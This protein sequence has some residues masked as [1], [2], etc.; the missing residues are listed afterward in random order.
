MAYGAVGGALATTNQCATAGC[1]DLASTQGRSAVFQETHSDALLEP[2]SSGWRLVT[3]AVYTGTASRFTNRAGYAITKTFAAEYFEIITDLDPYRG[4]YDVYI[5][6][7]KANATPVDTYGPITKYQQV[8]WRSP[9]LSS[10]THTVKVVVLGT[11]N[12]AAGARAGWVMVDAFRAYTTL[13]PSI[14]PQCLS[15]HADKS[16]AH[17]TT[18]AHEASS[19][20]FTAGTYSG[21]SCDSCHQ[22]TMITEHRR[23]SSNSKP[24][25]CGNCHPTYAP[26][27]IDSFDYSCTSLIPSKPGCHQAANSQAPHNFNDG[28]H[29]TT[30]TAG[31]V[32]C[33]SCHGDQ[34]SV[35]HDDTNAARQQ[36]ASLSANAWTTN[37]LTCHGP[38]TFPATKDCADAGCHSGSGVHSMATHP[39]PDHNASGADTGVSTTGGFACSTCHFLSVSVTTSDTVIEHTKASSLTSVSGTIGCATCH[40]ASYF[41]TNWTTTPP[42]TN[43]CVACHATGKAPAP[44]G[45][46]VAKHN[47]SLAATNTAS[48]GGTYCHNGAVGN[49]SDVADLHSAAR[50]GAG[51]CTSC[52]TT[53]AAVPVAGSCFECHSSHGSTYGHVTLPASD[54]CLTCHTDKA[55]LGG[56][57]GCA[58]CHENPTLTA[59]GT[60]YIKGTF[61]PDC[62]S[63]HNATVLGTHAYTPADPNHYNETTHTAAPFTAAA[64][65]TGADGAVAAEG[66]EC[67]LCHT[68][69]LKVAHATT[70]IG[71]VNCLGCH[72]DTTLGSTTVIANNWTNDRCTDCHDTGAAT[73]HDTYGTD[74]VVGTAAGCAGSGTSCHNYT[75]L[76]KLHDKSQQGGAPKYSTCANTGCHTTKDARPTAFNAANSCGSTSTG[77]HLT[78]TT[79]NH[80]GSHTFNAAGSVYNNTTV[81]GCTDSSAGCHGAAPANYQAA[82]P[83]SGCITGPCHTAANHNDVAFNDPNTCQNC[84]GGGA[85]N[86]DNA[87]IISKLTTTTGANGGHYNET[88]HTAVAA[89]LTTSLTTGGSASA[90]CNQCHNPVSAT[91]VDGLY[92]QHQ[93]LPAPYNSTTC[94]DCHNYS[95]GVQAEIAAKWTNNTCEDCHNATD[96]P[97]KS[98]GHLSSVPATTATSTQGCASA[99]LNCHGTTPDVHALHKNAAGGCSLTGCHNYSAQGLKPTTVTCG[100]GGG[101]HTAYTSASHGTITGSESTHTAGVTQTGDTS[102]QS[103]ACSVCHSGQLTV[104]HTATT[105]VRT[106]NATNVCLNCHNNS[107]STTAITSTWA[108]NKNTTS[109]CAQ[110]HTGGLARHTD[111]SATAHTVTNA[112]C[113]N[114]GPGCHPTN[115][116]ASVGSVPTTSSVI[117]NN[118]ARCHSVTGAASWS[119]AL[120]GTGNNVRYNPAVKSCGQGTGCHLASSYSTST[121]NHRIGRGDQIT[122]DDTTH[123]ANATYMASTVTSGTA[124]NVCSDCH[125][126]TLRSEHATT[127][128]G[129]VGCTTGGSGGGGCHNTQTG[130]VAASSAAVVKSNWASGSDKCSDCHSAQHNAIGTVHNGSST[131]GCASGGAGCHV[132]ADLVTLHKNKVGGGGCKVSGCHDAANKSLRP[133]TKTCGSGGG[134][135]AT[136]TSTSHGSI[137]GDDTTHTALAST[138]TSDATL[139]SFTA[140]GNTCSACHSSTLKSAHTTLT[141]TLKSGNT[142]W[143]T[144]YCANCHNTTTPDNSVTVI[145]TTKWPTQ[146]CDE[147]HVT[148]GNGKHSG[149]TLANHTAT[150]G[151]AG[152]ADGCANTGCHSTGA[153][154]DVRAIHN[155]V[156]SG[157]TVKGT[158]S[159]GWSGGCHDLQKDMSGI[160]VACGSGSG[161]CHLNHTNNNHMPAHNVSDATSLGCTQCHEKADRSTPTTSVTDIHSV[162]N[163]GALVSGKTNDGC[164]ICHGGSGWTDV[165]ATAKANGTSFQCTGCHNG[166]V[167][168]AHSYTPYDPNHY[169]TSVH[170]ATSTVSVDTTSGTSTDFHGTSVNYSYVCITCHSNDLKTEHFQVSSFFSTVPGTYADKCVACHE[171]KVDGFAGAAWNKSCAGNSN[172]C[173]ATKHGSYTTKHDASA[174]TMTTPGSS[175]GY[176]TASNPTTVSVFNTTFESAGLEGWTAAGTNLFAIRNDG[177]AAHGGT[178]D[179]RSGT[180]VSQTGTLS[181]TIDVSTGYLATPLREISFWAKFAGTTT[182]NS[183]TFAYSTNGSTWTSK[184]AITA[185]TI[186]T[187]WTK[188]TY[189][190]LPVS[191]TL[192]L[193]FTY[194]SGAT[195]SRGYLDDIVLSANQNVTTNTWT[196]T[197]MPAGSSAASSC[198][199]SYPN[200]GTNC[201]DVT[202]MQNIHSRATTTVAS[203]TY[204]GCKVC[205]RNASTDLSGILASGGNGC[206]NAAF[207]CHVGKNADA[208]SSNNLHESQIASGG[209]GQTFAGTGFSGSWCTGCHD[210]SI[211]LEHAL[212]T[213]YNTNGCA[214]CH[215]K[216]TDSNA[217]AS[218]PCTVTAADTSAT[219]HGDAVAGNEL[220]TDCHKTVTAVSPHASNGSVP[221]DTGSTLATPGVQFPTTWSGHRVYDGMT[222]S[223]TSGFPGVAF[224]SALP[225][226]VADWISTASWSTTQTAS[227]TMY[228]RCSDCHGTMT[229]ATG[230]HGASMGVQIASGYTNTY[231]TEGFNATTGQING[232]SIC[233]KCHDTT[234]IDTVNNVHFEHFD[235]GYLC[236]DCHTRIPHAWK[237]PRLLGYTTDPA[238]YATRAGV[239]LTA[240]PNSN[241]PAP[242]AWLEGNCGAACD[243]GKHPLTTKWP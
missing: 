43:T 105:S 12:A 61:A 85:V 44:H 15:C 151:T 193:R 116:I 55:S 26:Y 216:T 192:Y 123:T 190:D 97:G 186:G 125:I 170:D 57:G 6:G 88:T 233:K 78:K 215:K 234:N 156:T 118:C 22:K 99:G 72:T 95:A 25:G 161:G 205:H 217:A 10:G 54:E 117:H 146:S 218:R 5:D 184:A 115:N 47:Y 180:T 45:S 210:D 8:T 165:H 89:S 144:P 35:I 237:R 13:P 38:N 106:L 204:T 114:S 232:T 206:Q 154:T 228:V 158:D 211:D 28:N 199:A 201:H 33:I 108:T 207:P 67:S 189:S 120:I 84:H 230:P 48:C 110:C 224:T 128:I 111:A 134:C 60:R 238:P 188:Y 221:S 242:T 150:L 41:P 145:K 46:T 124:T 231:A 40:N 79:T 135:H 163:L 3:G 65:G 149:Y 196:T 130:S 127:S 2:S 139:G 164:N 104:E 66:K 87:P 220:C 182:G 159:N 18:F 195:A 27:V 177:T 17:G 133:S 179:V 36:H 132:T 175:S 109:A 147:C 98:A 121:A 223:K 191:T 235:R 50:P 58:T 140:A 51:N 226:A 32:D 20:A 183:I 143:T 129:A 153:T 39:A 23:D 112:G 4:Q 157:C 90:R 30:S 239:G 225:G 9:R 62:V 208:H 197:A 37:C 11:Y 69:T 53:N 187:T 167:V 42:T 24:A 113:G 63:C 107:A 213:L 229:G 169:Y 185:P 138:M 148:Y 59:N 75:D 77:C 227:A 171:A 136:Y 100:S 152:T 76:A 94:S 102:Y 240:I 209:A 173:H 214:V 219:I 131:Q 141:A 1:H 80:G 194:Q 198:G 166:T 178:Y 68:A 203:V 162:A 31:T 21:F 83:N 14:A 19:T 155:R 70:S 168:G 96:M 142:A 56:H 122:G 119:T 93:G 243:T 103:T 241:L 74:H 137:T 71:A 176:V 29:T 49:M 16:A 236:I 86:Y 101:C 222:G 181:R 200:G 126:G 174:T 52:H 212:L 82:H 202:S 34:V 172:G 73:T 7:V 91:L 92:T 64:Q 81:T 160:V